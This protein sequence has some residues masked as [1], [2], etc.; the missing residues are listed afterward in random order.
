M[1]RLTLNNSSFEYLQIA[2]GEWIQTMGHCSE[3]V[4]SKPLLLREFLH[5]LET[6]HNLKVISQLK[7][8]HIKGFYNYLLTRSNTVRGGA[9]S[10]SY[11]NT[12]ITTIS[13]F[14]EYLH[15]KGL[16]D[17]PLSTLHHMK[18]TTSAR[19]VLTEDEIKLL[20]EVTDAEAL[21]PRQEA[22]YARDKVILTLFYGCG[23]RRNEG[24][25]VEL[26]DV[27]LDT[28]TLYVRKGKGYKERFV[29]IGKSGAKHLENYIYNYR[30]WFLKTGTESQLFVGVGG[31]PL[32][33]SAI[34]RRLR[35]L[36]QATENEELKQKN[37]TLHCLRHSIATHLLANGM[38]LQKIQRFLGHSTLHTTQIYTHLLAHE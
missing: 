14:L 5:Y 30:S 12:H 4:R 36:Q 23:L 34:F 6:A 22:I 3:A 18:V 2:F 32:S 26:G 38:E 21:T 37:L 10:S 1:K 9:L 24:L 35:T 28:R 13:Q 27:N 11:I 17:L 15:H 29:P 7:I 33:Y 25:N 20:F 8:Q 31:N 19:T 16:H